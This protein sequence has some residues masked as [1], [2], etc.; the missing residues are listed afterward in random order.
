MLPQEHPDTIADGLRTSLS[1]RTFAILSREVE[2]IGT[3]TEAGIVRAMRMS[4]AELR[5][6]VEPSSSVPLACLLEGTLALRGAR[7]GIVI[8]G[9]N[10][11][12]DR[13]PWQA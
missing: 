3:A 6:V 7:V 2:A 10:V 1:E 12:L 5:V 13:L 11:D 9:G 4:W 8:T